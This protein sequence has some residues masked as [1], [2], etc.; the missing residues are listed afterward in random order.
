MHG[1]S[2]N[3]SGVDGLETASSTAEQFANGY[4]ASKMAPAF[5][6]NIGSDGAPVLDPTHNV[7]TEI[8]EAGYATLYVTDT[9][10]TIPEGVEAFTGEFEKT[11]LKLNAVDGKIA[12]EEP[13]VLK[14]EAGF[15]S[16]VPTT[17]ATKTEGNVLKGAAEDTDAAGKYILAKPGDNPVGFY[18]TSGGIIK[19]GK[20][21]LELPEESSIKAFYFAGDE[22]T[23]LNG[24]KDLNG[25]KDVIFNLAGQRI[26]K[27]QKGINIIG[28]KKVLK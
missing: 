18:K 8:T 27:T 17:G 1:S 20:A 14:G 22:A 15:Y 21:Y 26:S 9:D 2:K 23:G 11:W 24:L 13:V 28:G 25:S 4:V 7:V 16:F 19:A 10:L 6:Q 12:A 3:D 5:R